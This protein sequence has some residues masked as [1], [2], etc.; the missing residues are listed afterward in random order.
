LPAAKVD[1][2]FSG[3]IDASNLL[4]NHGSVSNGAD[5]ATSSS[6]TAY[7]SHDSI[8]YG[9]NGKISGQGAL[10]ATANIGIPLSFYELSD[11][12]GTQDP[13]YSAAGKA[14]IQQYSQSG[15]GNNTFTLAS[16][17]TL[18][19]TAAVAAVPEPETYALMLAGLGLVGVVA[20]RR[21]LA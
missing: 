18:T 5:F 3:Y 14:T 12:L 10:I 16:N 20:R 6:G 11:S 19:Y 9:T 2:P 4:G 17:G 15:F 7:V 21:K 13:N 8:S 1:S